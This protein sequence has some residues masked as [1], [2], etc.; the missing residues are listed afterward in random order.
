ML[1]N[2][3]ITEIHN[4]INPENGNLKIKYALSFPL[5][6]DKINIET[7]FEKMEE[8]L[9]HNIEKETKRKKTLVGPHLDDIH[10]YVDGKAARYYCSQGQQRSVVIA[11]K[12]AEIASIAKLK[13]SFPLFLLDEVLS[14]LDEEKR[15]A[16]LKYL[17]EAPFQSFMTA[18]NMDYIKTV[19]KAR[20][21]FVKNGVLTRKET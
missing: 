6:N 2:E 14:E 4:Q 7:L 1:L 8:H 21:S 18:L 17:E 19:K 3:E 12:L 15:K 5:V 13:G 9:L 11:L 20:I 16:L 10:I